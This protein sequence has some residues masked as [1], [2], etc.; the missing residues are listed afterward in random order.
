MSI[1]C[2][3][4]S[5]FRPYKPMSQLIA[6]ELGVNDQALVS[7]LLKMMQDEKQKRDEEAE[8]LVRLMGDRTEQWSYK[9]QM[10]DFCGLYESEKH[11]LVQQLKNADGECINHKP[12]DNM[13]RECSTCQ[14]ISH[15]K[16]Y[17][18]DEK[19]IKELAKLSENATVL[20]QGGGDSSMDRY[21][22]LIGMKKAFESLQSYYAG[23]ITLREPEYLSI[24]KKYST[25]ID[26]IPCVIQNPHG[27]CQD[28][29]NP[30]S[31]VNMMDD[32]R[33]LNNKG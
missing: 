7:E 11:Y 9:P 32:I 4:C 10:T 5:F 13:R 1:P 19:R 3:T 27:N 33:R 20:G 29:S 31:E 12:I 18:R 28:W 15:G 8:L 14:Y 23:K 26:F 21:I 16:G 24:C 30:V 25:N 17:A 2:N 6:L 22:Q